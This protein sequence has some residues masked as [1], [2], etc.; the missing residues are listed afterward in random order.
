MTEKI[1]Y[2]QEFF[3][4]SRKEYVCPIHLI[5]FDANFPPPQRCIYIDCDCIMELRNK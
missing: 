4:G 5:R 1:E 2:Q 3:N